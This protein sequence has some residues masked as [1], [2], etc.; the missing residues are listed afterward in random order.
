[1]IFLA[2]ASQESRMAGMSHQCLTNSFFNSKHWLY[3]P[4]NILPDIH[5]RR[6][7][8]CSYKGLYINIHGFTCNGHTMR[9]IQMFTPIYNTYKYQNNHAK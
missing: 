8:T 2:S 6:I 9:A 7:K 5:P 4:T 3:D 1:M